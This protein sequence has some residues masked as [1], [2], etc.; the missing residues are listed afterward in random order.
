[1]DRH[2]GTTNPTSSVKPLVPLLAEFPANYPISTALGLFVILVV[3]FHSSFKT[4]GNRRFDA[5]IIGTKSALRARWEFFRNATTLLAQGYSQVQWFL[6]YT[7]TW[8]DN[9]LQYKD[10]IFKLSG[11]DIL[12][13]PNR[14]V[15]ELRNMPDDQIS[16]IQAN[17]DV[18]S[19]PGKQGRLWPTRLTLCHTLEL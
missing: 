15:S 19:Q 1:M 2:N 12:V 14:Y 5:P 18:G 10:Q 13:V 11:H 8:T 16:S 7:Q 3:G 9:R 17:I 6:V 4:T